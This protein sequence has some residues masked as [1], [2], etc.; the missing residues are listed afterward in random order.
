VVLCIRAHAGGFRAI[1][2]GVGEQH[3][4]ICTVKYIRLRY[5]KSHLTLLSLSGREGGLEPQLADGFLHQTLGE[6]TYFFQIFSAYYVFKVHLHHYSKIKSHKEVNNTVGIT[7]FLLFLLDDRRIREVQKLSDQ[8][9][10]SA[11]LESG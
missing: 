2:W 4:H 10:G 6:V 8:E 7:F 1:L 11:I 5:I 3:R 9:S